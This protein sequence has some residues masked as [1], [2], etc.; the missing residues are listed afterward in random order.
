M[1]E[2]ATCSA[3][4]NIQGTGGQVGAD[5]STVGEAYS[6]E[7]LLRH[8]LEP[9][10]SVKDEHRLY[11][12]ILDDESRYFGLIVE[13]DE[14]KLV[15][16][17]NVQAPDETVTLYSDEIAEVVPLKDSAMPTGLLV[18]LTQEEILDLL[19]YVTANGA[20]GHPVFGK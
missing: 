16:V 20:A 18:T 19:A 7:E 12:I 4:H 3:C 1:F 2:A 8:V 10:Y 13:R 15:V 6:P 17:E 9:A 5:L 14:E 11:A